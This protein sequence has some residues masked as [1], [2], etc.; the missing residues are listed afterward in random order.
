VTRTE[1]I[2][3]LIG[4]VVPFLGLLAV[5]GRDRAV[6]GIDLAILAAMYLLTA[7]GVTFGFHRLLTHR[8]FQTPRWLE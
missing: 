4:V 7:V 6:D 5:I 3:N 1:R 2:A 8:A